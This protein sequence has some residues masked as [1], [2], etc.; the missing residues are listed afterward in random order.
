MQTRRLTTV[1]QSLHRHSHMLGA[2]RELVMTSAL[3]AFLLAI[4][5]MTK[6]SIISAIIFWITSLIVLRKIAKVDPIF[7]KIFLRHTK[8]QDF[9]PAKTPVWINLEGFKVKK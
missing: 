3:I 2:E 4:G 9:Y 7:S 6:I 8:Q 5:G 1:H